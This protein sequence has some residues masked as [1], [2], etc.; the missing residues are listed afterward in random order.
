M[1]RARRVLFAAPTGYGK[2]RIAGELAIAANRRKHRLLFLAPWR[3]LIPQT[4]ERFEALGITS[5]GVMMSGFEPDPS[6]QVIVG[7]VETI[8]LWA[9]RHPELVEVE[10]V[11]LDEAH[12][13]DTD[14]R[15]EMLERWPK[16]HIVGFTATPFKADRG[17]LGDLFDELVEATPM[18][19]LIEDGFLVP[20]VFWSA[21]P[22][23]LSSFRLVK[24][25]PHEQ[26]HFHDK[27]RKA[28]LVGDIVDEWCRVGRG[29]TLA[30]TSSV[31]ESEELAK[32]FR[33]R[34]FKAEHLDANTPE[35]ERDAI[36]GR[37]RDETTQ[38][39]TNCGVLSEGYDLP[40]I[41]T[42]ILKRTQSLMSYLQMCG[43]A[44]RSA[45]GKSEAIILDPAGNVYRFGLPQDYRTWSLQGAPQEKPLPSQMVPAVDEQGRVRLGP[46]H[47]LGELE[48]LDALPDD[49][50]SV[51][52]RL[53]TQGEASGYG[54]PWAISEFRRLYGAPPAGR[55]F[56]DAAEAYLR[57][58]AKS[59]GFRVSWVKERLKAL[60]G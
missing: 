29:T 26:Q 19:D 28:H 36:L 52:R 57:R 30:F 44:L 37:F 33:A 49:P 13:Y 60:Y 1:K 39:V 12:R 53:K 42:V 8:R 20:P 14:L 15:R 22:G 45:D 27:P 21:D 9:P 4:M 46:V 55:E 38:I 47:V 51:M 31:K 2:T 58:Q 41:E 59:S 6:A 56:R 24:G 35:K 17:G 3:E 16:A 10:V 34:G 5:V 18:R 40:L 54:M 25:S 23:T 11:M 50:T 7:S 43:R 32:A 48:R